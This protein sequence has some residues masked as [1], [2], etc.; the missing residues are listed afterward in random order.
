MEV[1]M[2]RKMANIDKNMK[3]VKTNF[4]LLEKMCQEIFNKIN[5]LR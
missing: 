2:R 5:R 3:R 1:D 4:K